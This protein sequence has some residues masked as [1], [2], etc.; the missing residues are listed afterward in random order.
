MSTMA[1][2]TLSAHGN[3]QRYNT[4]NTTQYIYSLIRDQKYA[5]AIRALHNQLQSHPNSRAA[6]SLLAYCYYYIQ[7]F[8]S[9]AEQYELLVQHYPDVVDYQINLAQSYYKAGQYDEA[10]KAAAAVT[11]PEHSE[12][13]L[14]LQAA[15]R[16]VQ[17]DIAGT[18]TFLT[19]A[20]SSTPETIIA[21]AGVLFKEGKYEEAYANYEVAIGLI[22]H[23]PDMMYNMALCHYKLKR[24]ADAMKLCNDII[25]KGVRE[26]PELSVGSSAGNSEVRSVGNSQTLRETCL[27]EAFNLKAAIEYSTGDVEAALEALN[28]MPPRDEAELDSITLHNSALC[29]VD[30]DPSSGFKKLQHVL[31]NPP[32]PPETLGNLV[33]LYI[34][35]RNTCAYA[36][37]YA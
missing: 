36:Y 8:A 30:K 6:L 4:S 5:E 9:A 32:H 23:V 34:K 26:H 24:Y 21:H 11:Q 10:H 35:V 17:D 29:S 28:D 14:H 1:D 37:T 12:K 13:M 33:L 3:A 15:I 7:D 20:D 27:L 25:E 16:Y 2:K 31:R 22:G 19:Q 18:Q